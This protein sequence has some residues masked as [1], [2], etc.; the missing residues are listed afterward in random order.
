MNIQSS[1]YAIKAFVITMILWRILHASILSRYLELSIDN[2][3]YLHMFVAI[4][5]LSLSLVTS[6]Y[7]YH[8]TDKFANSMTLKAKL[9]QTHQSYFKAFGRSKKYTYSYK[10]YLKFEDDKDNN[11]VLVSYF[12]NI[13]KYQIGETYDITI[14]SNRLITANPL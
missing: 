13:S 14:R 1:K 12:D 4:I 11:Y 9:L 6:F 3:Y 8:N 7:L 10:C 5:I 2:E